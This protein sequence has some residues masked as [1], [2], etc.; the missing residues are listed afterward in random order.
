MTI[1]WSFTLGNQTCFSLIARFRFCSYQF[2]SV[3]SKTSDRQ[4]AFIA[5]SKIVLSRHFSSCYVMM[6]ALDQNSKQLSIIHHYITTLLFYTKILYIKSIQLP[7]YIYPPM[8]W[9]WQLLRPQF[10]MCQAPTIAS[11]K[12]V[13]SQPLVSCVLHGSHGY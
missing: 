4:N 1:H 12:L 5:F 8:S 2:S 13:L 6:L 3:V 11:R 10:T 7:N 9:K